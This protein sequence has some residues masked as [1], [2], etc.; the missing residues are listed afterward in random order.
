MRRWFWVM[1]LLVVG[2]CVPTYIL[3]CSGADREIRLEL[4]VWDHQ[5]A[6]ETIAA[7]QRA[8]EAVRQ[9]SRR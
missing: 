5:A 6:P 7:A 9:E 1:T 4:T 3:N 8:C 2:G